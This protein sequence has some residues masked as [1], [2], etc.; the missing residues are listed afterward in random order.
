MTYKEAL[1]EARK[2]KAKIN[3]H[4][5]YHNMV[6]VLHGDNTV[7]LF[8]HATVKFVGNDWF[9]VFTEHHDLHVYHNEDVNIWYYKQLEIEEC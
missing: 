5:Y 3:I 8:N 1:E 9:V 2:L 7:L 6:Y 4:D